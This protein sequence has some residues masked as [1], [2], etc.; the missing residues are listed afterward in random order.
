MHPICV[1][2]R[3]WGALYLICGVGL[4]VRGLWFPTLACRAWDPGALPRDPQRALCGAKSAR[5]T[6]QSLDVI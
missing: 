2:G 5:G 1:A 3:P 4:S 6:A